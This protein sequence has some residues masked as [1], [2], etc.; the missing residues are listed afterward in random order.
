MSER[1]RYTDGDRICLNV[2]GV[3]VEVDRAWW[4]KA[5]PSSSSHT[6]LHAGANNSPGGA[7]YV[8][9]NP[10][11]FHSIVDYFVTG[12]LHVPD[13]VCG[14]AFQLELEYW[15]LDPCMVQ[16]CCQG[17]L[18]LAKELLTAHEEICAGE[19]AAGAEGEEEGEGSAG[20]CCCCWPHV[21]GKEACNCRGGWLWRCL[22]KPNSSLAAQVRRHEVVPVL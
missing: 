14:R 7:I 17:R 11:V 15:G 13:G 16:P 2:R 19:E 3:R 4:D 10:H 9:R 1:E 21:H 20:C 22:E 8:N 12:E 18:K 5:P 6:E